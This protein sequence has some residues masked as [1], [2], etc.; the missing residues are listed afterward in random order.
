M[1]KIT[2]PPEMLKA[3]K[4]AWMICADY[5]CDPERFRSTVLPV[6][7]ASLRW[8]SENP[9]VPSV[10]ECQKMQSYLH[11]I[12]ADHGPQPLIAEWQRRMFLTPEVP[13]EIADLLTSIDV[14]QKENRWAYDAILEAYRRGQRKGPDCREEGRKPY[15]STMTK[16]DGY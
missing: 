9:I 2:V 11:D 4:D 5:P 6:L 15:L 1:S 16:P 3:A 10:S 13:E 7:E 12:T 8:L 14:I